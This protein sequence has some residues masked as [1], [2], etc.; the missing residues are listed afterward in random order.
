MILQGKQLLI[1]GSAKRLGSVIARKLAA[2]GCK[3][4]IHC[5]SSASEATALL[6]ELPGEGHRMIQADLSTDDGV[7]H[8]LKCAGKFELLVNSAAIFHRP[9]SPEDL[10]S[11]RL[12]RQI[13]YLAPA[14]LL[15]YMYMQDIPGCAAVNITDAFA[16]LPGNGAYWQSKR[17]LNV[18]TVA[19]AEKW[20]E[21]N[22]RINAVAPGP[23]IPPPWA[24]ES[25]MEKILQSVP[26]HRPVSPDDLADAVTFLLECDSITGTILPLDGGITAAA[27]DRWNR[28]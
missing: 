6:K 14:R 19:L 12:Y 10:A 11:A 9:G 27:H 17:D 4:L 18:L 8:L 23:V 7:E 21:K 24:P 25:R 28:Y 3:V 15:E 16:L 22:C 2:K 5:S 20:A 13:N 1:T 26:M